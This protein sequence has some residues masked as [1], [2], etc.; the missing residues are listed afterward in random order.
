MRTPPPG[1][2]VPAAL[3]VVAMTPAAGGVMLATNAEQ[4]ESAYEA[5]TQAIGKK[6]YAG[7]IEPLEQAASMR[8]DHAETWLKLGI[9]RSA[10]EEWEAAIEAYSRVIELDPGHAKAHHNLGNVHFRRGQF[11]PAEAAYGRS[12]ELEPDYLLAAFHHGWTLRQLGRAE[13]AER[14]FRSCLELG[15]DDP[16]SRST[17]IDC[18]FGLASIRHRAGDYAASAGMMEQVLSVHRGHPEARYYLGM[19]YRQLGRLEEAAQQLEIHRRMLSAR[20]QAPPQ[21]D[22]PTDP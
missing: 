11:V 18:T 4:A 8:P 2:F 21:F 17:R 7:A 10:L 12:R 6:D 15:G 1:V 20:R 14:A 19:A 22:E 16:R 5:G 3:L 9:A 13:D